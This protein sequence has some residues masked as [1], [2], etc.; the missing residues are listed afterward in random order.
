MGV[1][2]PGTIGWSETASDNPM[3]DNNEEDQGEFECLA[4]LQGH[5]GGIQPIVFGPSH[6]QW[7]EDEEVLYRLVMMIPSRFGRRKVGIV[8]VEPR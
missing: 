6:S 8:T 3:L 4:V 7:G 2:L 1:F 5:E